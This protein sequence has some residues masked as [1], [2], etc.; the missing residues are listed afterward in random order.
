M[1]INQVLE[2]ANLNKD[3]FKNNLCEVSKIPSVSAEGW[4]KEE[5]EK[6]AKKVAELMK[7]SG[8]ENVEIIKFKNAHPYAYGELIKYKNKPTILLYAHHDVQPPGKL[9]KWKTSSPWIPT[10]INGRL[11]GRGVVDDKA[12]FV[13]HLSAIKSYLETI[14]N[15]PINIKFIVEG[16]EEIGSDN[17]NDFI[18]NYK[19]KLKADCIILTDTA[20]LYEGLPS[21]TYLLRG[22]VAVDIELKTLSHQV[23][24]GMWGGPLPDVT[25]QMC[26]L[27]STLTDENGK[28]LVK[29]AY[30]GIK[31]LTKEEKEKIKSLPFNEKMFKSDAGL[32]DGIELNK[33]D[34]YSVYEQLWHLP[35]LTITA[36]ES[37]TLKESAN[38][39]MDSVKARVGIRIVP[40]QEPDYILNSLMKHLEEN[41]PKNCIIKLKPHSNAIWWHTETKGKAFEAT[42][43]ALR[44]GYGKE[45]TFI[46]C[47]GTIP[48]VKP[49]SDNL[50]GIPCILMGL[51]D[52]I[53]HA[54]SENESL[55]LSD[56]YKAINSAIYL[57]DELSKV[58]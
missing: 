20:N 28:I 18:A 39:I 1:S 19:E 29:G 25:M 2:Y 47:G 26:K 43:N 51:E 36:L 15:L 46:G 40:N 58:L 41:K 31:E 55:S 44:K 12:G 6:S 10:E 48:F 45:P 21:I 57:Y 33:L 22:L 5:L 34:D 3:K 13:I 35:S 37:C 52:P 24:S 14:G 53:C 23:H 7:D 11:Y 16:E 49:F 50:G 9:E 32:L 56:F 17:L 27:L 42:C 54:H 38:Q 4:P 8:L 30:D